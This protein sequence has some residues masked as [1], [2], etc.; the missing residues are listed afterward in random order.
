MARSF[1]ER[2]GF[3]TLDPTARSLADLYHTGGPRPKQNSPGRCL[4]FAPHVLQAHR[5]LQQNKQ[6]TTGIPLSAARRLPA[7]KISR[8]PRGR[9]AGGRPR[10]ARH[11]APGGRQAGGS[12]RGPLS[13]CRFRS[14][15]RGS[16]C[17]LPPSGASLS[18]SGRG[19]GGRSLSPTSSKLLSS[20]SRP[21]APVGRQPPQ[22]RSLLHHATLLSCWRPDGSECRTPLPPAS[23]TRSLLSPGPTPGLA[24]RRLS[25]RQRRPLR[26]P[27][28]PQRCLFPPDAS[29]SCCRLLPIV[30]RTRAGVCTPRRHEGKD[31]HSPLGFL[32]AFCSCPSA[33][34]KA[35]P[36]DYPL[37]SSY[38]V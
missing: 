13:R 19:R 34:S 4:P 7:G 12:T 27:P 20:H 22:R 9:G 35:R 14:E 24:Q 10:R 11:S 3:L 26:R 37:G 23:R 30:T 38:C 2:R 15:L 8:K 25:R 17:T 32:L 31:T 16:A 33:P 5:K 28:G 21:P 36:S 29:P 1:L 18:P 6:L